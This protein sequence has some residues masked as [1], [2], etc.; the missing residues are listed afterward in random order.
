MTNKPRITVDNLAETL[1]RNGNEDAAYLV[2]L[3]VSSNRV[4]LDYQKTS[5]IYAVSSALFTLG[6]GILIGVTLR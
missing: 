3:L 4:N 5:L 6:F 1:R 2:D